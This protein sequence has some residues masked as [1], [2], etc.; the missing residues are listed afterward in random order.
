MEYGIPQ[1]IVNEDCPDPDLSQDH[2]KE[3]CRK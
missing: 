2:P 1:Q 3:V